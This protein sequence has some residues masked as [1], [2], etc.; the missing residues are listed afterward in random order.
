MDLLGWKHAQ[1]GI[2]TTDFASEFS[3]R[4]DCQTLRAP[5]GHCQTLRAPPGTFHFGQ[6]GRK[7]SKNCSD[8]KQDQTARAHISQRSSRDIRPPQLCTGF[9]YL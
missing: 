1:V 8:A 7:D 5:P 4:S 2:E 6:Q 9:L 3:A